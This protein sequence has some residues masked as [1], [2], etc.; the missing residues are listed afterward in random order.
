MCDLLKDIFA[1][2]I[3][4]QFP[5]YYENISRKNVVKKLYYNSKLIIIIKV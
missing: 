5:Y 4:Y 1:Y 2:N 3:K